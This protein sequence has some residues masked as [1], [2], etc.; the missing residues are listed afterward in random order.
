LVLTRK[1]LVACASAFV[2]A[3]VGFAQAA[4]VRNLPIP[5]PTAIVSDAQVAYCY[6]RVRG[7]DP[8]RLPQSYLA[9]QL[10]VTVSYRNAATRPLI[11]PLERDRTIYTALKPGPLHEFK[12][13]LGLLDSAL[14]EMKDL[15]ANVSPHN[16]LDP[17]NDVFTIIPAG[18]EMT[19]PISEQITLPV[20]RQ[21]VF[22]KYPDLRG[23]KVRVELH[24]THRK[25]APELQTKLSDGWARYGV[26]WSGTLTTNTIIIDVPAVPAASGPCLDDYTPAHPAIDEELTK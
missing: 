6:A 16:P 8:T 22:R 25:L 23:Q 4:A 14:K 10:R 7:L 1:L 3:P 15:P 21:G 9:L 26:P 24:F 2:Y 5:N 11:L 13:G 12:E 18:G 20:N 17:K 19:P